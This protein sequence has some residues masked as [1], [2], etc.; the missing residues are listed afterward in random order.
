MENKW[1]YQA[2]AGTA[3]HY[4]LQQYFTK[5]ESGKILG[6]SER[7]IIIDTIKNKIDSDLK[8]SLGSRYRENLYNDVTIEQ[9]IIYADLLKSKLRSPDMYGP[10]C[11]FYPELSVS[12]KLGKIDPNKP[13]TLMG[14]IDLAVLDSKG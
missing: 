1:D 13:D 9:A 14:I 5:D 6:D 4:I 8:E 11:E 10:N 3:I 12:H 2:A 7:N